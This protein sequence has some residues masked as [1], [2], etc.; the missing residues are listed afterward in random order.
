VGVARG[1]GFGAGSVGH[2]QG[3]VRRVVR[4][5]FL[6]CSV[7]RANH[8][9]VGLCIPAPL[10]RVGQAIFMISFRDCHHLTQLPATIVA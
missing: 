10:H 6:I 2:S 1:G 9:M 8:H 4:S 3:V 5:Y 7:V